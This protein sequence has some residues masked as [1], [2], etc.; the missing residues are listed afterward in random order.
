MLLR[1]L[2]VMLLLLIRDG[3][4]LNLESDA[5]L[6]ARAAWLTQGDIWWRLDLFFDE[7]KRDGSECRQ[8]HKWYEFFEHQ[9]KKTPLAE[10]NS[11]GSH[12]YSPKGRVPNPDAVQEDLASSV[13]LARFM[14]QASFTTRTDAHR[15]WFKTK[16][17]NAMT[18]VCEGIGAEPLVTQVDEGRVPWTLHSTGLVSGFAAWMMK[19]LSGNTSRSLCNLWEDMFKESKLSSSLR[20]ESEGR[21]PQDW[22]DVQTNIYDIIAFATMAKH[23]RAMQ[24]SGSHGLAKTVHEA[25]MQMHGCLSETLSVG[26]QF[27]V[28]G[29]YMSQYDAGVAV[30]PRKAFLGKRVPLKTIVNIKKHLE[31]DS[32][33]CKKWDLFATSPDS[34]EPRRTQRLA[35]FLGDLMWSFI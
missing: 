33:G 12:V 14:F 34:Q 5:K 13:A 11:L 35:W 25:F 20:D 21:V 10:N 32:G 23:H 7:M 31:P 1:L 26:L 6:P 17:N 4:L 24:S 28:I 19:G 27:Y 2:L 29:D 15:E 9:L 3:R 8:Y 16:L 30:M 18:R 22:E